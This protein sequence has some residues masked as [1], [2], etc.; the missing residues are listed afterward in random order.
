MKKIF[1]I[2]KSNTIFIFIFEIPINKC[3]IFFKVTEK[4][5]VIIKEKD[6]QSLVFKIE[7]DIFDGSI[8]ILKLLAF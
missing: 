5:N 2:L 4:S 1:F 6:I 7:T 8:E 3:I